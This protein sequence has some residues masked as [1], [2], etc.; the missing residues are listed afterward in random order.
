M[1][2]FRLVV[3]YD[4]RGFD[5]WQSQVS[6]N[7]IQDL[8]GRVLRSVHPG[9]AT[10]QGAGRTDAGVHAEGQVA[11]FDVPAGS[12]LDGRA[13]R[14]AL[15]ARLPPTVRVMEAEAAPPGFHARFSATGK[16]YR[17]EIWVGPVLPPWRAGW[18]WHLRG[19]LDLSSMRQAMDCF[20]GRHDFTGFSANRGR[21]E[22][23]PRRTLVRAEVTAAGPEWRLE[24]EGDGFLYKMVRL[25]TGA[26]VR[27]G[28]GKTRPEEVAEGLARPEA[29]RTSPW[30]APPDGLRLVRVH[31]HGIGGDL[32]AAGDGEDPSPENV[33]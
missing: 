21:P 25:M 28:Q 23:D 33:A 10:V 20:V 30:A 7:G 11:H 24:F 22:R 4:G 6:G 15:N 12:R 8:L 26:V 3:A 2:R 31:Y 5:G 13:W 16:V 19:P 9:I 17:Y 14:E 32:T 27:V 1:T 18:A 29:R